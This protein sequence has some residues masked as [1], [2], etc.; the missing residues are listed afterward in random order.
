MIEMKSEESVYT[1]KVLKISIFMYQKDLKLG[2]K[3][4]ERQFELLAIGSHENRCEGLTNSKADKKDKPLPSH[5]S[6]K[7]WLSYMVKGLTVAKE[8]VNINGEDLCF[9]EEDPSCLKPFQ[10]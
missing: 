3:V 6:V 2:V 10:L 7:Q 1:L 8:G 9:P 4:S 5:S